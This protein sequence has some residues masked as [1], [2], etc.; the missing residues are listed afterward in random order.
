MGNRFSTEPNRAEILVR[1]KDGRLKLYKNSMDQARACNRMPVPMEKGVHYMFLPSSGYHAHPYYDHDC[2]TP[3]NDLILPETSMGGKNLNVM[4]YEGNTNAHY[5]EFNKDLPN[6]P[7]HPIF[8]NKKDGTGEAR[9]TKKSSFNRCMPVPFEITP[10]QTISFTHNNTP[11]AFFTDEQCINE[12]II[13]DDKSSVNNRTTENTVFNVPYT[14]WTSY[15]E[16]A[17]QTKAMYYRSYRDYYPETNDGERLKIEALKAERARRDKEEAERER[18]AQMERTNEI[19]RKMDAEAKAAAAA[20]AAK[21]AQIRSVFGKIT[22]EQ[23]RALDIKLKAQQAEAARKLELARQA[24]LQP[25]LQAQSK[26]S[27]T[28]WF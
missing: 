4:V 12:Y 17:N 22:P 27:T 13:T 11:L 3:A 25:W 2:E 21:A 24:Q 16:P 18:K 20:A 15:T 6:K 5:F 19:R 1:G 14:K 9:K 28:K 8:F 7:D 10:T 26:Q 23:S